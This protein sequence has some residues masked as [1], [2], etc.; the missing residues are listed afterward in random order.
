MALTTRTDRRPSMASTFWQSTVGKKIV[1]GVTG[2]IMIGYLVVH[3][4]ANA[5]IF[6]GPEEFNAYGHWLRV[7]GAP[8]LHHEW[9]LWGARVIL[10]T[11]VI[12]HG[13]SAYQLSRRDIKARPEKYV[14]S[15]P[16]MSYATR[17]MRWGG[18]ILG[19]F[20]VWHVLDLTTGTVHSGG[21]QE[22]HPYQNVVDTFS[23]WYGNVI[24]IVAMLAMG[25]HVRHGFWSAAQT[26]G[27]GNRTRDRA[28][29]ALANGLAIVLTV[30]FISVPV[31]VMTGV[32]S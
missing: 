7:M 10:L 30:G 13:V 18:V 5:K 20:I 11:S 21:F 16:R 27:A 4:V 17:T 29:K 9:G 12:L 26:L 1:M 2:L 28:F 6:F 19:L 31:G 25:M 24:Y 32:V 8:V 23:T 22:G 15:K 14:H 3:M